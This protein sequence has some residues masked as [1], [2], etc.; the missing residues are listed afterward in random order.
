MYDTPPVSLTS[1]T[2]GISHTG[3][4]ISP[5]DG[6][7]QNFSVPV[8]YTVSAANGTTQSY[9]VRVVISG[10]TTIAGS[11]TSGN[12][13][14]NGMAATFNGPNDL[15]MDSAGNMYVANTASHTIRK[16]VGEN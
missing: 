6:V 16:V 2:P 14:G 11:G 15:A 5:P 8:T 10:V 3:A 4:S 12:A 9:V 1:M 7:P 13:N